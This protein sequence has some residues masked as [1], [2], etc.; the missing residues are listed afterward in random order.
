MWG[1]FLIL[2]LNYPSFFIDNS[3]FRASLKNTLNKYRIVILVQIKTEAI[4]WHLEHGKTKAPTTQCVYKYGR[5][6][7]VKQWAELKRNVNYFRQQCGY[8]P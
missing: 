3:M 2:F 7:P 6:K 1:E 5:K 4:L 8:M